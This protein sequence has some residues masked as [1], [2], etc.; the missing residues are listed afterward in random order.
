MDFKP[1]L[2]S[3]PWI[4]VYGPVILVTAMTYTFKVLTKFIRRKR[5]R[6]FEREYFYLGMPLIWASFG[7]AVPFLM[8]DMSVDGKID[9]HLVFFFCWSFCALWV[10]VLHANFDIPENDLL[11]DL[12]H[13]WQTDKKKADDVGR[14]VAAQPKLEDVAPLQR[15]YLVGIAPVLGLVTFAVFDYLF[16]RSLV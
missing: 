8:A 14:S 1:I 11:D 15:W 16:V 7:R 12:K 10:F 5:C 3:H 13:V 4:A 2:L 6:F 9:K